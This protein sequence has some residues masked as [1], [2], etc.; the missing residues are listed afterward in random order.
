MYTQHLFASSRKNR[1][2]YV[3]DQHL[4]KLHRIK[5]AGLAL[6]IGLAFFLLPA[7]TKA[8]CGDY[9][10]PGKGHIGD[11]ASNTSS[12]TNDQENPNHLPKKGPCHG[13]NCSKGSDRIPAAPTTIAT[14]IRDQWLVGLCSLVLSEA[15][16]RAF[17]APENI[18][19]LVHIP[20][21]I[22]RPPRSL[23]L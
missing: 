17:A 11:I 8:S 3:I 16:L 9:V 19:H 12:P 18:G 4:N 13:P 1:S 21:H 5:L 20:F 10:M 15:G 7:S 22:E 14:P 2:G 6:A 23:S